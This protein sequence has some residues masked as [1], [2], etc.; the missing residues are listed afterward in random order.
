MLTAC[1]K[2]GRI[3]A[4][5][6][7]PGDDILDGI[8]EVCEKYDLRNGMIIGAIG[9]LQNAIYKKVICIPEAKYHAGYG[10]DIHTDGPLELV[11]M[12][13]IICHSDDGEILPH[14]HITM[15]DGLSGHLCPGTKVAITVEGAIIETENIN[16]RKVMD[17]ERNI[18]VFRPEQM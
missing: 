15:N 6:L 7:A 5:K 1:G 12:S 4:F 9:S 18:M 14:I 2:S 16:M 17:T 8:V 10:D 13:G 11:G 3:V